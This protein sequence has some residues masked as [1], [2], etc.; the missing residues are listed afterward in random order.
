MDDT[1]AA[2]QDLGLVAIAAQH[3]TSEIAMQL[4]F[5]DLG[6]FKDALKQ[7][8]S[9]ADWTPAD[10]ARLSALVTAHVPEGMWEHDLGEGI[11]LTHGIV[12]GTYLL[13]V[14]GGDRK[15]SS[16]FDRIFAGPV[17]PE[18]TP[19]PRKVKFQIGGEAAP[20]VWHRR[21]EAIDDDR[22]TAL[23][24][25]QAITDVMVA[26]DFVTV[27]LGSRSSW[28]DRLD[29]VLERVTELFWDGKESTS[30]AR[31]RDELLAEAGSL[32][33]QEV[34]PEDLHLMDP[35]RKDHRAL[36]ITALGADDPRHRRAAVATLALSGDSDV[37]RAAVVTGYRD[38]S[39][40]VKRAAIDAAGDLETDSFRALFEEAIFDGDPWIR[41]RAIR[42]IAEIGAG[43][44]EEQVIL[45]TADE[46]FQVRFEANAVLQRQEPDGR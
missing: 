42:A 1:R 33:V 36:L 9:R 31:T 35:D 32:S 15:E 10:E 41:W 38:R 25:D 14:E 12:E 3:L 16:V 23:L 30:P 37:A 40:I 2:V 44:S 45:A 19:H 13:R 29:P 34:R 8:F 20:G 4:P 7:F 26:G 28:E 27:G 43:P 21:G 46:D 18:T 6:R 24:A 22:V 39:R 11:T 17:I 5:E